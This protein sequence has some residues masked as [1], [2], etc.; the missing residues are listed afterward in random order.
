MGTGGKDADQIEGRRRSTQGAAQA[1]SGGGA[2][3][4]FFEKL[5]SSP[6]K[7]KNA[8]ALFVPASRSSHTFGH[9]NHS[10]FRF[11]SRTANVF[12]KK[13]DAS[14]PPALCLSLFISG[15]DHHKSLSAACKLKNALAARPNC[16]RFSLP[17]HGTEI[18]CL[19]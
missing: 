19:R 4:I 18:F 8:S 7:S 11:L 2:G 12:L 10:V 13:T 14:L 15:L 16:C 1:N 3:T 6:A 17:L 9:K 5:L